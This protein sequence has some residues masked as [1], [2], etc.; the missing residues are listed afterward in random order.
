MSH[1]PLIAAS[2]VC[3]AISAAPALA[4]TGLCA[5]LGDGGQW[6]GGSEATS[7]ISTLPAPLDAT[8][9]VLAGNDYVSLFRLSQPADIRVEAMAT[10]LGDSVIELFDN[11]GTSLVYD[12]DGG[13]GTDS[14]AELPLPAGT[15]CLQVSTFAGGPLTGTVR[16]GLQGHEPLTVGI[17]P[18]GADG[19]DPETPALRLGDG[20]I[21]GQLAAGLSA[22][23]SVVDQPFYRFTLGAPAQL[24]LTA[25]NEDADPYLYLYDAAGVQLAENDDSFGLNSQIDMTQ[26]LPAGDYCIGVRALSDPD[27]PIT[28]TVSGYDEAGAMTGMFD[29]AEAA[30]PLDGAHP[31]TDL[32]VVQT[33]VRA[34]VSVSNAAVWHKID[35]S[36]SGLLLIEAVGVGNPDPTLTVFDDFGRQLAYNDDSGTG[37]DSLVALPVTPG[38][39]LVAVRQLGTEPGTIRLGVQRYVPAQ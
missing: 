16:V 6:V 13:G 19:C 26:A 2:A 27:L 36:E 14:R 17:P 11:S 22:T 35:V 39:Y 15:Y 32:G 3:L 24:T 23:N 25:Q 31:I 37:F 9:L 33:R 5:G 18:S 21:D 20:P 4:Q 38:T 7:D 30:P 28:V 34:D 1:R 10:G 8:V 29:T 12:D